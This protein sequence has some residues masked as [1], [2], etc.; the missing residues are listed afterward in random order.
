MAFYA[1]PEAHTTGGRLMRHKLTPQEEEIIKV[2][3][4]SFSEEVQKCTKCGHLNNVNSQTATAGRHGG[5]QCEN[6]GTMLFKEE[7]V[8]VKKNGK[9]VKVREWKPINPV[10]IITTDSLRDA[11]AEI[12]ASG[13][14]ADVQ[15]MVDDID[16]NNDGGIDMNE[17]WGI[18]T[19]KLLG[20]DSMG[21]APHTF[22]AIDDNKDGYIPYVELRS[23]LMKEGGAPLSEQEVDELSMFADPDSDGLINYKEFLR[24][25]SNPYWKHAYKD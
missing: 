25:L 20:E 10:A 15:L 2:S 24:W 4:D 14:M 17:W 13:D 7:E 11:F 12:N 19:R 16:A 22:E 5:R 3:F 9:E 6:C 23:I 18:M 8:L 1:G 21:S